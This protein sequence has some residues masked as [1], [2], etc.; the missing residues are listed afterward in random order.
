MHMDCLLPEF[1]TTSLEYILSLPSSTARPHCQ[2]RHPMSSG[3]PLPWPPVWLHTAWPVAP[4]HSLTPTSPT[5]TPSRGRH[6]EPSLLY[7]ESRLFHFPRKQ[8]AGWRRQIL[9]QSQKSFY[10]E[11]LFSGGSPGGTSGKEPACQ[12][13]RQETWRIP[14]RRAW[15]PTPVFSP[16]DSRGQRSLA[17]IGSQSRTWLKWLSTH[18]PFFRTGVCFTL[19]KGAINVFFPKQKYHLPPK[20]TSDPQLEVS[21]V[22]NHWSIGVWGS[23]SPPSISGTR[24]PAHFRWRPESLTQ[25]SLWKKDVSH[26]AQPV[27]CCR[28]NCVSPPPKKWS[29]NPWNL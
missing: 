11:P 2:L 4:T 10:L 21:T 16:G 9:T 23:L 7:L 26:I 13:R 14:C 22:E 27:G 17:G 12:C 6:L 28:L 3:W 25:G 29:S 15:Q 5:S 19:H 18:A 8:F 24:E 1:C 20:M